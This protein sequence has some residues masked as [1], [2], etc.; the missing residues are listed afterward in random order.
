MLKQD[1]AQP[2]PFFFVG[3]TVTQERINRYQ[4]SKHPLLSGAISKPDTKSVWY[5]RDHITQLLAEMEKANADGLRIHLG[6]YG[7]N[8]N[9]SGQ[10]CLL[11]VMTQVDEQGRQV[12]ITIENA[13]DFQARSLDPDQTRDFNVGSPCPPIC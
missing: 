12:D 11:M 3:Q 9:Y 13:P 4:E 8:E 7:E 6:M 1:N 10:L 5:T 2:L